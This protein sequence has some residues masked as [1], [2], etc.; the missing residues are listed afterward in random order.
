MAFEISLIFLVCLH[1]G[2]TSST[3]TIRPLIDGEV[4]EPRECYFEINVP[5]N[6]LVQI[7]CSVISLIS[8]GSYLQ[9][10]FIDF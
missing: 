3:G 5:D 1:G 8:R 9:V 7:S 10:N 4:E 6:Q 2:T